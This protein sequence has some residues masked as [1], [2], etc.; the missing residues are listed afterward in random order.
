M[1]SDRKAELERKKAKLQAYREEK[2]RRRKEKE[3]KDVKEATSRMLGGAGDQKELD[4]MLSSLGVAPVSDILSSLSSA[5]SLTPDN[6]INHTPDTSLQT[7]GLV[8]NV[9]LGKRKTPQLSVVA[10][11]STSIPPKETVSYTKQ[12][13]TTTSGHERDAHATDYYGKL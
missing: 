12:T 2:D 10:V 6:S 5:N 7:N 8:N 4:E 11:Q 1:M 9:Y 13:Q 3:L